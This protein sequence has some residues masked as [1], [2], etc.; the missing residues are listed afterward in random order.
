MKQKET[1][2]VATLCAIVTALALTVGCTP[3]TVS[4]STFSSGDDES[5]ADMTTAAWSPDSDCVTCHSQELSH[6]F[7]DG[8][9]GH[10]SMSCIDCHT[11]TSGLEKAHEKAGGPSEAKKLKKT[12]IDDETCLTC[13]D[14]YEKLAE[15]TAAIDTLTDSKGT[16]VNPHSILT[17]HNAAAQHNDVTCASCHNAHDGGDP[18]EVADA[19]C[20]TCHHESVYECYTCHE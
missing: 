2:A 6:N 9:S 10:A 19:L 7:D 4:E 8:E 11:D 14:S 17:E 16:T 5:S 18:A 13:H 3:L 12:A 20:E 1:L 15:K